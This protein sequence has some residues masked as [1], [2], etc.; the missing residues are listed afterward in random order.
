MDFLM[1]IMAVVFGNAITAYIV[2]SVYADY[3][4]KKK[5]TE[6]ESPKR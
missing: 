4:K 2:V 3:E 1:M 6:D 5:S